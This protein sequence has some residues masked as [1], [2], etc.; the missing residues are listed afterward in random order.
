MH[1]EEVALV[2][3][4]GGMEWDLLD[5]VD[6]VDMGKLKGVMKNNEFICIF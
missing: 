3:E 1:G 5:T 4:A 6:M 2:M